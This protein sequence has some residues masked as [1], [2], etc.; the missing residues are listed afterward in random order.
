MRTP[1]VAANWKMNKGIAEAVDFARD[2]LNRALPPDVE[3][4]IC[5]PYTAI[6]AVRGE[7]EAAGRSDIRLGAQDVHWEVKG[8]FTGEISAFMA[9]DAGCSYSIVGHSERRRMFSET[10]AMVARKVAGALAGGLAPIL[11]VG[12]TA[13]ERDAGLAESVVARQVRT[14]LSGVQASDAGRVVIAYEPVWAIGTGRPAAPSDAGRAARLIRG[15]L[16]EMFGVGVAESVRIQYGGSVDP[17]NMGEFM[18]EPGID[19]A[20]VGGASLDPE[21]FARIVGYRRS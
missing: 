6:A 1:I 11:C 20:L 21:K 19:G 12:E 17:G 13:E 4:V 2:F 14:G 8:A 16:E 9:R 10:D 18:S 15:V 5:P 7:L 3:V